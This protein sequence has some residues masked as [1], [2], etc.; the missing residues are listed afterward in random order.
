MHGGSVRSA[1]KRRKTWRAARHA[2]EQ[3]R[4]GN[5]VGET[6]RRW[7]GR[8]TELGRKE[9]GSDPGPGRT[10]LNRTALADCS[11]SSSSCSRGNA[12]APVTTGDLKLKEL[13]DCAKFDNVYGCRHSPN[14]G[15]MRVYSAMIGETRPCAGAVMWAAV[16]LSLS[17][18]W[19]SCVPCPIVTPNC[20]LQ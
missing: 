8:E 2:A 10:R 6:R 11:N 16:A 18:F 17:G 20:V 4:D 3:V 1:R 5:W 12:D 7:K 19:C 15:V 13:D 14:D 9:E